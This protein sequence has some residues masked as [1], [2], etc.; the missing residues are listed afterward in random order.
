VTDS[1]GFKRWFKG[2]RIVNKDGSPQ[3]VYHGTA[4]EFKKFLIGNPGSGHRT[5]GIGIWFTSDA[6]AASDF[7]QYARGTGPVIKPCY[8]R[9]TNPKVYVEAGNGLDSFIV[10]RQDFNRYIKF[11]T[12]LM[13]PF[14]N[15]EGEIIGHEPRDTALDTVDVKGFVKELMSNGYDGI[16]IKGTHVDAHHGKTIDQIVAFN[17]DQI[18]SAI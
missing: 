16:V 1:P 10:F 2:S 12:D 11:S 6:Y 5:S 3:I 8:L 4:R 9:I 17:P 18:R 13:T 7:A 15:G 14:R